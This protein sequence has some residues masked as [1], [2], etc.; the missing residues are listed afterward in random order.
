M[1]QLRHQRAHGFHHGFRADGQQIRTREITVVVRVLLGA[2]HGRFA[3]LVVPAAGGLDLRNPAVQFLGLARGFVMHG[4]AHRADAVQV[5]QLDLRAQLLLA[6]RAEGNVHVAPHLPFFH[7]GVAQVA[8]NQDLAQAVQIGD[9]FLRALDFRL[10]HQLHQRGAR[11]VEIQRAVR[12]VV[13]AFAHVLLQVDAGQR[14]RRSG[15]GD[16]FLPVLRIRQIIQRH[17]AAETQR[18]VE[19][20]SLVVL[21]HVRVEIILPVPLHHRRRGTAEQHAREDGFFDGSAI[22]HRQRARQAEADGTG[23]RV[24]GFAEFHRAAAEHLAPRAELTV[25]LK[26]DGDDVIFPGHKNVPLMWAGRA[27]RTRRNRSAS[28]RGCRVQS[29][30]RIFGARKSYCRTQRRATSSG[31]SP[32]IRGSVTAARE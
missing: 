31:S 14:H 1:R 18:E 9:G 6:V 4:A 21:R 24:R 30:S 19:L 28:E 13:R 5:L 7:V 15:A 23:E 8:V 25:N 12:A 32:I 26:T 22:Q 2:H 11:T 3:P 27:P 17:A 29:H 16:A 20:R 10:A